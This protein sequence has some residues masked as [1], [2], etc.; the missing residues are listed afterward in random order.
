MLQK[1]INNHGLFRRADRPNDGLKA[2]GSHVEKACSEVNR[3][4]FGEAF[5]GC[6]GERANPP[7]P[8]RFSSNVRMSTLP[9]GLPQ[10]AAPHDSEAKRWQATREHRFTKSS[11]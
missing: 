8:S 3:S 11:E 9:R 5:L 1:P 4:E 2:A 10:T 7:V 6:N